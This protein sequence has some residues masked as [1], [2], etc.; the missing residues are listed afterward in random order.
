MVSEEETGGGSDVD[1][2]LR[3]ALQRLALLAE[4]TGALSSTLDGVVALRRL[5]Q[6]VLPQLGDWCSIDLLDEHGRPERVVVAHWHRRPTAHLEGPL[7]P[8]P[9]GSSDPLARVLRGAGPLLVDPV[10]MAAAD[11]SSALHTVQLALFSWLGARSAVIAPLRARR[12]VLGALTLARTTEA[13][14]LAESDLD[15]VE[16]LTH[17][18]AQAV[19]NGHLY[20]SVR[21]IAGHLQRALLPALPDL[22][23]LKAVARYMPARTAAEV[24]GDWYDCFPLPDGETALII[25]DV[26]G[27]DLPAAITMGQMRNMLR[28]LACD[29]LEPP[30]DTLRRLD[31]ITHTLYGG[32]TA[33]CIY[34]RLEGSPHHDWRLHFANAGHPPP[35]LVTPD[36]GTRYLTTGHSILLGIE[37]ATHRPSSTHTLP[38]ASTLLL[39]TDGLIERPGEDLDHGLARLRQHAAALAREPLAA[40]CDELLTGCARDRNDDIALLAVHLPPAL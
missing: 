8:V 30:G 15:L 5:C 33:T 28:A 16:D 32:H 12:Q 10:V 25:G 22:A 1:A 26:T 18:T 13:F 7:P 19:D 39:Y 21:N 35:L 36:G 9:E 2:V 23:P 34:A 27:H 4:A 3:V 29:R 17:R 31:T 37:P 14:A 11:D 6:V 20:A 24:G 40:F 38:A